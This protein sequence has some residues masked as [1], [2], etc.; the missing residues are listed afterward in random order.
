MNKNDH[1]LLQTESYGDI[2]FAPTGLT[3]AVAVCP[4]CG[5]FNNF[6]YRPPE[7]FTCIVCKC[8]SILGERTEVPS[9]E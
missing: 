1:K 4:Q 3:V 6:A 7:K 5:S 8:R 2:G 9:E